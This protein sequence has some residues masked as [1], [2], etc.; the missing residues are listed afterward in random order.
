M[1]LVNSTKEIKIGREESPREKIESQPE[2]ILTKEDSIN[3]PID[4]Q[5]LEYLK[6]L[7]SHRLSDA[8][9]AQ[10]TK[11][12]LADYLAASSSVAPTIVLDEQIVSDV[13]DILEED[14]E[15]LY[16]RLSPQKQQEFKKTGEEITSKIAQM[17]QFARVRVKDILALIRQWLRII[18]GVNKFFLEQEA[19]IKAD[20]ILALT[21][22]KTE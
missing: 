12:K 18:P 1:A 14:L 19:K 22:K 5:Q 8:E 15:E 7:E 16:K 21:Q 20:K 4:R 13:E 10:A 2:K 3:N 9:I 17:V 11:D 6:Q